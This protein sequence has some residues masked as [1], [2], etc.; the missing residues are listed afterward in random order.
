M[1][2]SF[3]QSLRTCLGQTALSDHLG[4]EGTMTC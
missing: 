2:Y 4:E 1:L 3:E